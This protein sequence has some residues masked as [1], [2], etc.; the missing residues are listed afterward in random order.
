MKT[1]YTKLA[2]WRLEEKN[3]YDCSRQKICYT[4][5]TW[6]PCEPAIQET[7]QKKIGQ[8]IQAIHTCKKVNG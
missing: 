5:Y 6:K 7:P 1:S 4:E 3:L 2:R 8:R